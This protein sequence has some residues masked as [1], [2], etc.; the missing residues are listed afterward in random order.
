[1]A[2]D[3]TP[4]GPP[5]ALRVVL[6]DDEPLLTETLAE[7]LELEGVAVVAVTGD[8]AATVAA[9]EAERPD[10]VVC[11]RRLPDGDG[12][13]VARRLA[14]APPGGL[15][16]AV[17]MVSAERPPDADAQARA[18]GAVGWAV[19]SADLDG[20]VAAVRH[21]G[22]VVLGDVPAGDGE[23]LPAAAPA[24]AGAARPR[25]TTRE[26]AVLA[27]IA[28]GAGTDAVA[29]QLGMA[30][31]TVRSHVERMLAK[32]A[33]PSRAAAVMA[34]VRLGELSVDAPP[35]GTHDAPD[36]GKRSGASGD[37]GSGER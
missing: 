24:A 33:V 12:L 23:A 15:G 9:C 8:V 4:T 2:G 1:M 21:V 3:P 14:P 35:A 20:L 17:L 36:R 13:E 16:L 30:S 31:A 6:C 34:A 18:A 26:R 5:P 22:R 7:L 32:L 28:E 37:A 25:L 11:D 10:V 29:A 19:K 27:A